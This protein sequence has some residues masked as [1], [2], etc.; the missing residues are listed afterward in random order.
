MASLPLLKP[1]PLVP[2]LTNPH[3]NYLNNQFSYIIKKNNKNH[4]EMQSG[5]SF[6]MILSITILVVLLFVVSYKIFIF[7]T[8]NNIDIGIFPY[9]NNPDSDGYELN[10][11]SE[12]AYYKSL[13]DTDKDSY[14]S[15][16][17]FEK[18]TAI[19]KFLVS[20]IIL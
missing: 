20:Q 15:L 7:M 17:D 3:N 14:L 5:I 4:N 11:L 2:D 12:Q 6:L 13:S 1:N 19:K 10:Y 18:D 9:T 8:I 16:S